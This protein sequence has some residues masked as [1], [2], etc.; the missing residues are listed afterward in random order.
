MPP[1]RQG[2]GLSIRHLDSLLEP[3]SVAVIGA[4]D[5]P[6]SPGAV[7]WRHL[8]QGRF[9]GPL[10]AVNPHRRSLD[11]LPVASRVDALPGAPDL[12]LVCVPPAAVP[13][14]VDQLGAL[15]T[16]AVVVFGKGIDGTLR[17]AMLDAARRHLVRILGP[18]SSG[19]LVPHIGLHASL[20][21]A[22]AMPGPLALVSQ[23]G[24]LATALLDHARGRG[25]GFSRVVTLG[26]QADVDVGDLLD[27]LATD[28]RTRAILLYL[29]GLLAPRK[30]MS[31]ARAA[32]RNKPVIVLRAARSAA[33]RDAALAHGV[34]IADDDEVFDAAI[35]RA[36]LV[37]VDSLPELAAA[38]ELLARPSVRRAAAVPALAVLA[39][40]IGAAVMAADAA[41]R[42]GVPLAQPR[43]GAPGPRVLPAD[44]APQAYAD[45]ASAALG[46]ATIGSLLVVHAPAAGTDAAGIADA[47][48]ALGDAA[49]GR[50]LACWLG[51]GALAE[52]E[53]RCHAGGLATFDTPDAAVRAH[54]LLVEHARNHAQLLEAPTAH[55]DGRSI[56][57]PRLNRVVRKAFGG[58]RKALRGADALELLAAAGL[59]V[60]PT[61]ACGPDPAM[62]ERAARAIGHPVALSLRWRDARD[63]EPA[64]A[65]ALSPSG[66]LD[67]DEAVARSAAALLAQARQSRRLRR[68][69]GFTVQAWIRPTALHDLRAGSRV[70]RLFGPVVEFEGAAA[71]PPLNAALAAQLVAR[72]SASPELDGAGATAAVGGTLVAISRL[73]AEVPEIAALTIAPLRICDG[74][75]IVLDAE[76]RLDA[77][78]PG[79][80]ARFAI[81]PYPGELVEQV[82]WRGRTLTLRPIR[83]GDE[84]RHRAFLERLEPGDIRLRV[85][86][87]RRTIEPSE[88]ARLVQ[89]DYEREMAFVAN[90]SGPDGSE[91]TLGVVRAT[92][93]PDNHEAE[94]GIIVRSDLKGTGLGGL[95]MRK[96]IGYQ[97]GRGTRRLVATVLAENT[98]ML[99]LAEHMGFVREP[100][101]DAED[102][103]AIALELQ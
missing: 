27:H 26:A 57:L 53:R 4:T 2:A 14:V 6:G 32:A 101:R 89:I 60:A 18:D 97:R 19:L 3:R 64:T 55:E 50:L 16:H 96:L 37:R 35:R 28:A 100:A 56:D 99:A 77:A 87:S 52:A 84:A 61:R 81:R 73:L 82:P 69:A 72:V 45:E 34:E 88:L 85:F 59:A 31:A 17:S 24:T 10:W 65:S 5:R 70:D 38:A 20:G 25:L 86:Y 62:A 8:R 68:V 92:S 12:A 21:P 76:V 15:G 48:A 13:E 102:T 95:L 91:E 71:L 54:A 39:N 11:G 58:A 47:L 66:P 36:G 30:F 51:G 33:G 22:D 79:G 1:R 67:D 75:V 42:H 41:A 98:R 103:L 23:S 94:F 29:E 43:P 40:G 44:A 78:A 93:D 90:A 9:G 83:P 7:V 74:G 80:A 49:R 63:A 46:N